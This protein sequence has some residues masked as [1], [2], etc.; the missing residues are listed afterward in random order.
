MSIEIFDKKI[1]TVDYFT[2]ICAC[3]IKCREKIQVVKDLHNVDPPLLISGLMPWENTL[4]H[5]RV[6]IGLRLCLVLIDACCRVLF[7]QPEV[8]CRDCVFVVMYLAKILEI[9]Y[10]TTCQT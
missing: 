5:S 10:Y 1:K 2:L 9:N 7:W 4:S 8:I 6:G 3:K